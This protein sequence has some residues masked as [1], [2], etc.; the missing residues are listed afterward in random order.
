MKKIFVLALALW[1]V[2]GGYSQVR[3]V[4]KTDDL[5]KV[6]TMQVT[7]GLES[8]ENVKSEP[9]MT[10]TEGELDYTTYDWQTNAG[11]RNWT[12]VWPDG[13]ANFAYNIATTE[14]YSDMGTG[15]G[16]YNSE[17]DEW[18]PL[19]GRI[20]AEQTSFGSIARYKDNGIVVAANTDSSIGIFIVENKDN[21]TP[22]SVLAVSYLDGTYNPNCPAVMTSGPNRDIIHIIATGFNDNKLYYFRSTD[23]GLTWDKNNVILPYL[24]E[25]YGSSW[26]SHVAYWMETT[27]DNCLALVV[28]N[29][30]SDGM[31]IYSYDDGEAWMRKVFYQHPGINNTFD[32]WFYYPRWVSCDWADNHEL[33]LAYEFNCSTGEPGSGSYN[34]AIGG[35]AF[36]SESLPYQGN[37]QP[38]IMDSQYIRELWD[39]SPYFHNPPY[40]TWPEYFGYVSDLE[41]GLP[42]SVEDLGLH[43]DYNCGPVAMPILFKYDSDPYLL[44]VWIAIDENYIDSNGNYYFKLWATASLNGGHTWYP[45]VELSNDF[46][47]MLDEFVFPQAAIVGST[48]VIVVQADSE[49]G[50]YVQDDDIDPDDCYY[51]GFTFDIYSLFPIGPIFG[52]PEVEHNTHIT[53]YPNPAVDR[54][55]VTLNKNAAVTIYNIMGQAVMN[56]NGHVGANTIDISNL[57]SGI[58]YISA[59]SDTQKFIVK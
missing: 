49:T 43:G 58:Y 1:V 8:F 54:L 30:W 15:I 40:E 52:T 56:V 48:L 45:K 41:N 18:I 3:R 50:T 17:C 25:E 46:M 36:W 9:N 53:V 2:V 5:R 44:A 26:G 23:G 7:K 31:V 55:N 10:R 34:P 47:W 32:Y 24:T 20:E 11:P 38:F 51:Q 14:N 21:M 13:K 16:T 33:R 42:F 22:N 4:S 59:G 35:V 12:I 37:G 57:S 19:G 28:N 6:S 27:E 39:S 29:P